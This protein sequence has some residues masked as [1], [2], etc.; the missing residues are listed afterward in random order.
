MTPLVSIG[1]PV[2]N[3]QRYLKE[4][5]DSL[6]AQDYPAIEL[7]ISDNASTDETPAICREY[8]ARDARIRYERV[9][10][11]Q[12]AVWNFNRVYGLARGR[13]F[14]WAAFDDLRAPSYVRRCVELLEAQP[15]AVLCCTDVRLIDETG[16]SRPP[17]PRMRLAHPVGES[18]AARVRALAGANFWVDFYGLIRRETLATTRLAQPI[19]GFDLL[20]LLELCLRGQVAV[21]PEALFA[22]RIFADKTQVDLAVGLTRPGTPANLGVSWSNLAMEMAHS[23]SL[24]PLSRLEKV[25]LRAR[26]LTRFCLLNHT[27]RGYVRSDVATSAHQALSDHRFGRAL[28]LL[29]VAVAVYPIQ[30]DFG[31]AVFQRVRGLRR[32]SGAGTMGPP[33]LD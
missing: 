3:A 29:G 5:L 24:A 19:W 13:Y 10:Q 27:V 6:I 7:I 15:S 8:A 17:D 4:A 31:K 1:I 25:N 18:P 20:M 32:S 28:A 22:Y 23:I 12:G 14:M 11:N 30:H 2:Y 9:E 16:R 26:F 33:G 21:V